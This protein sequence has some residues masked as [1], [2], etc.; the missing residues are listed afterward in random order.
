MVSVPDSLGIIVMSY[1][2]NGISMVA[3]H[4]KLDPIDQPAYVGKSVARR[5]VAASLW[6]LTAIENDDLA[7]ILTCFAGTVVVFWLYEVVLGFWITAATLRMLLIGIVYITPRVGNVLL[8][9][10]RGIASAIL[11]FLIVKPLG[12]QRPSV[13][14][15]K[16]TED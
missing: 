7:W 3:Y 4:S 6:P 16:P 5:I 13:Q 11:W 1:F 10:P 14:L 2:A 9:G 15:P 8:N 12:G